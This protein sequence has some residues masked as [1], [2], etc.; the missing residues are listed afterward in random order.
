MNKNGIHHFHIPV[1]GIGFT[2]DTPLKVAKYGI[3]SVISLANDEL[4]EYMR[5]LYSEQ[6]NQDYNPIEDTEDDYR[7]RRI[8]A[9][10]NL[11]NKIVKMQFDNLTA[12][13]FEPGN[14]ITKYFELLPDDGLLKKVYNTMMNAEDRSKKVR[15]QEQ[16][17][18]LMKPGSIDVNIMVKLN[19]L[20]YDNNDKPLPIEYSDGIS[21]LRGFANSDLNSSVVFS[22]GYNPQI[23]NYVEH[24]DD[25]FPDEKGY[26]KKKIIIKVSTYRSAMVQGKVFAKKGIFT[27]E[28]RLESGLNCGGHAFATD[29]LLLGPALE[30]LKNNRALLE[31]ELLDMCNNALMQKGKNRFAI[32]PE[33]KLTVQGGLGTANEQKFILDYY[34]L[35][36]AGWGSPFLLVPEA[37]N[38]DKETLALLA[39]AKKED[40]YLSNASPMGVP[41]NNF[42]K[43]TSEKQKQERIKKGRPGSPCYKKFLSTNTEFTKLPICTGSREYQHSKIKELKNRNLLP[44]EYEQELTKITE[45]ECLCEGL[46]VAPFLK[47]NIPPPHKLSAVAICPGPNLAYFSGAFTLKEMTDHIYG[48]ANILNSVKR[49]NVFI[50]ELILYVDYFKSKLKENEQSTSPAQEKYLQIFKENLVLGINYYKDLFSNFNHETAAYIREMKEHLSTIEKTIIELFSPVAA[51]SAT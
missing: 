25:F 28:F 34:K 20:N 8:T 29:G 6:Y 7:A 17:R 27:S 35:D 22:A 19:K 32:P 2:V 31:T 15:L 38:V 12:L 10:L 36:G 37:T 30:E 40:Y 23:Y 42:R 16:L 50:N 24:F 5:K 48:R 26:V 39:A 3:S 9:Y 21:A 51:V 13:P 4:M 46:S 1:M 41:F 18:E 49:P 44:Q 45:K 33:L 43:S 14:E 47:N 11:V